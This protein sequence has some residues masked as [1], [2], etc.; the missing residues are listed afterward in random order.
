MTFSEDRQKARNP[1]EKGND[2]QEPYRQGSKNKIARCPRN[3]FS[4]GVLNCCNEHHH[5]NS[6]SPIGKCHERRYCYQEKKRIEEHSAVTLKI[7]YTRSEG[8]KGM[9]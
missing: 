8:A 4:H 6:P 1:H 3:Q 5:K 2:D 9:P 7:I